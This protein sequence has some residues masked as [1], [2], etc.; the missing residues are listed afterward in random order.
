MRSGA[1]RVPHRG[2]PLPHRPEFGGQ[3]PGVAWVAGGGGGGGQVGQAGQQREVGVAQ[4]EAVC[5]PGRRDPCGAQRGVRVQRVAR[6]VVGGVL[7]G[8]RR[9]KTSMRC[10][11]LFA[12]DEWYGSP[13]A[14][15]MC[16]GC[17]V[18]SLL[19]ALPRL[20]LPRSPSPHRRALALLREQCIPRRGC[21][22]GTSE[23][24]A[25]LNTRRRVGPG[26]A[27]TQKPALTPKRTQP[28]IR[29]S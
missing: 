8:D 5:G 4:A 13:T 1:P 15:Q 7:G 16:H 19:F 11:A 25:A 12:G 24:F 18:T 29:R 10:R 14:L 21:V 20:P 26:V 17:V 9:P 27:N 6:P 22:V 2:Q 3:T 28:Q 23:V